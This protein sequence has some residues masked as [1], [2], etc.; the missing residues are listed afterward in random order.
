MKFLIRTAILISTALTLALPATI[1]SIQ[2]PTLTHH[3]SSDTDHSH[4]THTNPIWSEPSGH[5]F[6]HTSNHT[7]TTSHRHL[8]PLPTAHDLMTLDD[9]IREELEAILSAKGLLLRPGS[10]NPLI[11]DPAII[12]RL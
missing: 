2:H 11:L 1:L 7:N 8:P 3:N 10:L 6:P 12:C 9:A 5:A 4:Y